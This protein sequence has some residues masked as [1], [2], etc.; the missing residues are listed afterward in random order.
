MKYKNLSISLGRRTLP[1]IFKD[2]EMNT[3]YCQTAVVKRLTLFFWKG[4]RYRR[5]IY[6]VGKAIPNFLIAF[7]CHFSIALHSSLLSKT[8]G[9]FWGFDPQFMRREVK[10][11]TWF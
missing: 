4:S 10:D 5:H 9:S 6:V 11:G 2:K 7:H 1:S 3:F 8:D